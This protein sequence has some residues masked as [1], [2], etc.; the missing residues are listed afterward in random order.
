[1]PSYAVW[2]ASHMADPRRKRTVRELA[3]SVHDLGIPHYVSVSGTHKGEWEE[4]EAKFPNLHVS[5]ADRTKTQFEHLYE[6]YRDTRLGEMFR[7]QKPPDYV[8]FMDDDDVL[9]HLPPLGNW[10][11]L[12][13]AYE[14]GDIGH[15]PYTMFEQ[16]ANLQDKSK[17]R[18]R[19]DFSGTVV[20]WCTMRSLFKTWNPESRTFKGAGS[21]SPPLMDLYVCASIS[22]M[23][24][25]EVVSSM[26]STHEP[27]VYRRVWN[28]FVPRH[29]EDWLFTFRNKDT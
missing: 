5:T 9:L 20:A 15:E 27:W 13:Y 8:I 28:P 7:R 19:F 26:F 23:N 24:Y 3:Q 21:L 10:V 1:M 16:F 22:S 29:A 14:N 25:P 18:K 4:L 12:Q 11:G 2:T 17:V 6:I